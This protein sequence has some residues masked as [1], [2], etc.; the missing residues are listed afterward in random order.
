MSRNHGC[1]VFILPAVSNQRPNQY[2]QQAEE[3]VPG[4]TSAP[5]HFAGT[6]VAQEFQKKTD[7]SVGDQI[8]TENLAR[9]AAPAVQQV[10]GDEEDENQSRFVELDRMEGDAGEG[11]GPLAEELK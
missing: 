8:K 7:Q 11:M 3:L 4:K 1:A 9:E 10:E 6:M 5:Q 2:Q